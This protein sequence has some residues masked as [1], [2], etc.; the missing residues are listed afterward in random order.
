M[1]AHV[2][3][4][5]FTPSFLFC[6]HLL[7]A[8]SSAPSPLPLDKLSGLGELWSDGDMLW[9]VKEKCVRIQTQ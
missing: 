3:S 1:G 2:T 7:S 8:S 9:G 4:C 5:I 6:L